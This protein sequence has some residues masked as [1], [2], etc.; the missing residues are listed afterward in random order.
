MLSN[1]HINMDIIVVMGV[2]LRICLT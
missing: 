1:Y 2:A